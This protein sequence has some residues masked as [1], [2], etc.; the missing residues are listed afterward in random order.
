[1]SPIRHRH[2]RIAI[3]RIASKQSSF[4]DNY[5]ILAS[6]SLAKIIMSLLLKNR[7][8]SNIFQEIQAAK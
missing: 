8:I 5:L 4:P 6:K 1:M 2:R 7:C 3:I